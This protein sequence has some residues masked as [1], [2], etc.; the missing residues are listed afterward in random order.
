MVKSNMI[1]NGIPRCELCRSVQCCQDWLMKLMKE[2]QRC[3]SKKSAK[4][5]EENWP[6]Q[7]EQCTCLVV[8]PAAWMKTCYIM[9]K[10][11]QHVTHFPYQMHILSS[12]HDDK[13]VLTREVHD[14]QRWLLMAWCEFPVLSQHSTGKRIATFRIRSVFY[15]VPIV[16]NT[17]WCLRNVFMF[18]CSAR[19][20]FD[21]IT[22]VPREGGEGREG[23]CTLA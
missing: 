4:P 22:G 14:K 5:C 17:D 15:A 9:W 3:L 10:E 12:T 19:S 11:Q 7:R 2:I 13:Q 1:S 16:Q 8:F 18:R 21:P 20:L 23:K 6:I